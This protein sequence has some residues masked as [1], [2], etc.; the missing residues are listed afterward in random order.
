MKRRP[1][2]PWKKR[3]RLLFLMGIALVYSGLLVLKEWGYSMQTSYQ[4]WYTVI[5]PK[6][7]ALGILAILM[8]L[9]GISFL[10][11]WFGLCLWLKLTKECP[12]CGGRVGSQVFVCTHC[13]AALEETPGP[14]APPAGRPPDLS[15]PPASAPPDSPLPAAGF[16]PHCGSPVRPDGSFCSN[17]GKP[18]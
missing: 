14:P 9:L 11:G 5:S 16:C 7:N 2:P 12:F 6:L 17:C 3:R 4:D 15:A 8:T 13:G 1:K 18:L 10:A